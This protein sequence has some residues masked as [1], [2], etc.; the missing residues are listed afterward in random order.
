MA[1]LCRARERE[2][3]RRRKE[4]RKKERTDTTTHLLPQNPASTKLQAL[5]LTETSS[6]LH[7][8]FK[9]APRN[10][11]EGNSASSSGG[12]K[13]SESESSFVSVPEDGPIKDYRDYRVRKSSLI[14]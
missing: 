1:V 9:M 14:A 3:E 10:E 4:K 11:S 6:P 5:L 2:R 13:R 12:M 7:I 8:L